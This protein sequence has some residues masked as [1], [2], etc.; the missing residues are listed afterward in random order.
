M[1]LKSQT[2]FART[3]LLPLPGAVPRIWPTGFVHAHGRGRA[4]IWDMPVI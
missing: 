2:A 3:D 1:T 4:L